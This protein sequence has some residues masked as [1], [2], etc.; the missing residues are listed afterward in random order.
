MN[1]IKLGIALLLAAGLLVMI[2]VQAQAEKIPKVE[3]SEK[4]ATTI[5]VKQ[6]PKPKQ[7]PRQVRPP[8]AAFRTEP[9]S[10]P[11]FTTNQYV[12]VTSVLDEFGRPSESDS[13]KIQISCGGQP[14]PLGISP[15]I[16]QSSNY[17][18][19]HGYAH[20]AA[21]LHGDCNA[22]GIINVGDVTYLRNYLYYGGPPPIPYEAGDVNCDGIINV[23]DMVYL[24]NYLWRGGPPPCDPPS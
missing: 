15:G 24:Q 22:N 14:T 1:R 10:V 20:T 5:Q 16:S 12:L 4:K 18:V 8:E 17:Q 7:A 23:G 13:F 11:Q 19:R 3:K 21:V 6:Q 9:V 2:Q